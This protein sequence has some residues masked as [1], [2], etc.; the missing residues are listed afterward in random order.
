MK[1]IMAYLFKVN[2]NHSLGALAKLRKTTISFVTSVRPPVMSK[3]STSA[4]T[5]PICMKFDI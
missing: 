1:P 5:E 2:S 4:P 3:W